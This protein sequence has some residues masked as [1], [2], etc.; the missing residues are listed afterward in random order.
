MSKY[1]SAFICIFTLSALF[2]CGVKNHPRISSQGESVVLQNE[3]VSFDF[4]LS[5]GSYTL[6]NQST[7]QPVVSNANLRINN[8]RSDLPGQ[9][10]EW[11][12]H[13]VANEFGEGLA[14][15]LNITG[16]NQPNLRFTVILYNDQ[17]FVDLSAGVTNTLDS[18]IQVKEMYVL[19]NGQLY[20]KVDLS[21]EFAMIDGFSGGEPLEYGKR[22]YSPL[23]RRNALKSRNNILLTFKENQKRNTLIM[24]G[25]TYEDFD[26]YATI[27]QA[28]R[29]ELQRGPDNHESLIAYLNLPVDTVDNRSTKESLVLL[30]GKNMR[31]WQYHEFY[32]SEAATTAVSGDEIVIG[33]NNLNPEGKYLLGLSWWRSLW[34]GNRLDHFQSVFV[35][36]DEKGELIRIPLFENQILPLYDGVKK[37]GIEQ[38]EVSLPAAAIQSGS[39]KIYVTHADWSKIPKELMAPG[40]TGRVDPNVYL[41]EIWLR[42]GA[43][44]PLLSSSFIE[45]DKSPAPRREFTAQLFAGDPV[46]K[47]VDPGQTYLSADRFYI[48]SITTDPFLGLENYGQ[49]V[50]K[51]QKVE[52][53]MYDFPS[54]CLW[55]A[56]NNE[57]GGGKAENTSAGAVNEMNIIKNKG[58]LKYSRAAVRLVPDSYMPNNQ[59]G[60]WDDKHWQS[61]V[62]DHNGS[63]NGRYVEPYETSEKWGKA[64]TDLGGIP[65]TYFQ[66][67]FRSEDY[68]KAFPG[69]MLFNRQYAWKGEPQDTS[70][71]MFKTWN[72]TWARNGKLWGYDYTDPEFIRHL[73]EVYGNMKKG[74]IRG[75]MFDYP[76]S[77]WAKGGGMED[78]YSTTGHAY[79]N[80]FKFANEGLGPVAYVHERN[81]ER[82]T[83]ISIGN[84]ASM[85]TENDTDEMDGATV[86]RCGLR[87]YKNRVLYNQ[88]TDSKNIV[89]LEGNRDKVRAVLT[90]AYVTTGRLLLANSFSQFSDDTYF[91]VTRTFPYHT[92]AQSARP[93]DA[94]VSDIPHVYDFRVNDEWHQVTFYNSD[95]DSEKTIGINIAGEQAD[96]ALNLKSD[97]NYLVY[98]FWNDQLCGV[99]QGDSRIE[100]TLRPGEARM[101]SV[102]MQENHPQVISTNRHIMQGYLDLENVAWD[103]AKKELSGTSKVIGA[104]RYVIAIAD[105]GLQPVSVTTGSQEVHAALENPGKDITKII[106]EGPKNE[107]VRWSIQFKN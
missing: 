30:K 59:Q 87:W 105:N 43:D 86:T 61:P 56:E 42:N 28:R 17:P 18:A 91:D 107:S 51:A 8:W 50:K 72:Q 21:K 25:L 81:M 90:M 100:Q 9:T 44:E 15:D 94:F 101:L 36:Y 77:G 39:M 48:N 98:D 79:R 31:K 93:V 96:G 92:V 70:G 10:R 1:L 97:K 102:R 68:A 75:L 4:D 62:A 7:G 106:L 13:P 89:R 11:E 23:T 14:L 27:E 46:G 24:G 63:K 34:H 6:T 80:I 3:W 58:F 104:D 57:Y 74:G 26:K 82:G 85:R 32:P 95:F 54:V 84:I 35:E 83:D 65:L 47:K 53:S 99:Y 40:Q 45:L 29:T 22:F 66:T 37:E 2:S 33:L 5:K 88:D 69:H 19:E 52:L 78:P 16:T 73:E 60:W 20:N 55:Y 67:G 64:V 71:E 12:K 38:A 49:N 103:A 76:A 41:S